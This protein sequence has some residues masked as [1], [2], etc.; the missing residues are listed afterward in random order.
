MAAFDGAV[1]EVE[2]PHRS[3]VG[4]ERL[5]R[6]D[7]FA[8]V[9][10][11]RLDRICRVYDSSDVLVEVEGR[12]ELGPGVL[13]HA[14]RAGMLSAL[15]LVDL[16]EGLEGRGFVDGGAEGLEH[17]GDLLAVGGVHVCDMQH[18]PNGGGRGAT[19][20]SCA[21]YCCM[22]LACREWLAGTVSRISTL[23]ENGYA[24]LLNQALIRA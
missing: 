9:V 21:I 3:V 19:W 10:V 24:R 4:Q 18:R 7:D 2:H 8:Q 16:F 12:D 14:D 1:T 17:G 13:E 22:L 23:G 20:G 15:A 6:F 11:H 5:G